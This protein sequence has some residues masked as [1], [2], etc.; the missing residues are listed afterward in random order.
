MSRLR[1]SQPP[2]V[3]FQI[4]PYQTTFLLA[5]FEPTKSVRVQEPKVGF[6]FLHVGDNGTGEPF[7]RRRMCGCP[8]EGI[9]AAG[10]GDGGGGNVLTSEFLPNHLCGKRYSSRGAPFSSWEDGAFG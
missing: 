8:G 3:A 4:S 10:M 9:S 2:H 1:R 5:S 7:K 6:I